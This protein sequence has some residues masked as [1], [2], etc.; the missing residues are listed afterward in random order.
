M[1]FFIPPWIIIHKLPAGL[2]SMSSSKARF[3]Q[4]INVVTFAITILA[5]L[6]SNILRFEG[7]N[8]GEISDLYPT[9]VTPAG[10]VFAIWGVIYSLLLIFTVYQALPKQQEEPFIP[11]ISY[12]FAVSNVVNSV[13]LLLWLSEEITLSLALMFVLLASLIAIYVRLQIGRSEASSQERRYVHLP[14][15]VYLGW[16]TVATIANVAAAL[17]AVNWA[18]GGISATGWAIILLSITIVVTLAVIF[19]RGDIAYSLVIVW[20]L[21]GIGV[22][23]SAVQSI[24]VAAGIG[25][26]IVLGG[27]VVKVLKD[28]RSRS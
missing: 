5:N 8:I 18:G 24:V 21:A 3:L 4:V 19:T 12:L 27:V 17:V 23:Q 10:Y 20:A 6:L 7:K 2:L 11:R 22:K 16:I 13:W 9:L 14:F 1:P 28:R 15:S 25:I 26:A